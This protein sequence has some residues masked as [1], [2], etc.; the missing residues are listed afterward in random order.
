MTNL[1]QAADLTWR[2]ARAT[3]AAG[4]S[5]SVWVPAVPSCRRCVFLGGTKR[6]CIL[7]T[8]LVCLNFPCVCPEPVLVK[9]IVLLGNDA[10]R[11]VVVYR[12]VAAVVAARV[13]LHRSQQ[14]ERVRNN[15]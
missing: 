2:R 15:M 13:R 8:T 5:S 6:Q 4:S 12:V 10:K 3:A 7:R 9:S 11:R 14:I 1:R